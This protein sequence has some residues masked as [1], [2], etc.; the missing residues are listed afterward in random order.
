MEMKT[1]A[2]VGFYDSNVF[3]LGEFYQMQEFDPRD[4]AKEIGGDYTPDMIVVSTGYLRRDPKFVGFLKRMR[5]NT[6]VCVYCDDPESAEQYGAD[7]LPRWD[8][9]VL[10]ELIRSRIGE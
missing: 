3:R 5:P 4:L 2:F 9:D 10:R 6:V 1:I 8:F 7:G